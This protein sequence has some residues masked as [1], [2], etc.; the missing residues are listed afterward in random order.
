ME[1]QDCVVR[2][3]HVQRS[4]TVEQVAEILGISIRK[5]YDVCGETQ[6]FIVKRLGPRCMRVNRGSFDKWFNS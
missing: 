2:N 5:A 1:N 3:E 4:Y 6:D